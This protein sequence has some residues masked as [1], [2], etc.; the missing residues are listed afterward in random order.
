MAIPSLAAGQN[1]T[2]DVVVDRNSI[3]LGEAFHMQIKVEGTNRKLDPDLSA[4]ENCDIEF[5]GSRGQ[6]RHSWSRKNGRVEKVSEVSRV[7]SYSLTPYEAGEFNAGPVSIQTGGRMIVDQGVKVHVTGI[8][9][10]ELVYVDINASRES[11]L[12]V[13]SFT[14]ALRIGIEKLPP[15]YSSN[16]PLNPNDPPLLNVPFLELDPV[17]GLER[18][19][20]NAIL[21]SLLAKGRNQPGF[22]INGIELQG[23][24]STFG[25]FS[26]P[27]EK[28]Q[29]KFVLPRRTVTKN[30]KEYFEY[31][32]QLDYSAEEHGTYTFGPVEFKGSVISGV[33][34]NRDAIM[35]DVFAVGPA[36][37]VRVIPP[38]EEGRPPSYIGAIGSNLVASS[39]LDSQTCNVGDPLQL[40]L[41][42][43]GDA[44]LKNTY[45]P[46][47]SRV[48]GLSENFKVYSDT[49]KTENGRDSR[50][51]IYTIRPV[52]AGTVELPPLPVSYFDSQTRTYKTVRTSA[53]PV[54]VRQAT[55][56]VTNIVVSTA[57]DGL[58]DTD[59]I[60]IPAPLRPVPEVLSQGG[61]WGYTW[62]IYALTFPPLLVLIAR[63]GL[64]TREFFY[65]RRSS[66]L[67]ARA[68]HR[69]FQSLDAEFENAPDYSSRAGAIARNLC[70][71]V[72]RRLQLDQEALT[73]PDASSRLQAAGV[74]PELV[75]SFRELA[76]HCFDSA[77]SP[78][79]DQAG[80]DILYRRR[81]DAKQ[82]IEAIE[83]DIRHGRKRSRHAAAS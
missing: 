30:G 71:Y 17:A 79:T 2:L 66:G 7:Y 69:T 73:P 44:R 40:S 52:S 51:F 56:V 77:Y 81:E 18:P 43:S 53:M 24:L 39:S 32:L 11:T 57:R 54:K 60:Y 31:H 6:T 46:E 67:A 59:N 72:S 13:D 37:T 62:Q 55:E 28:K 16:E 58:V 45:P 23:G 47:I 8:E 14:I 61:R 48:P 64:K 22:N 19:D 41:A 33:T 80:S 3:Y 83:E 42:V 70:S 68:A 38:P 1:I 10:Q 49:V 35:K 5:L 78:G 4:I 15:P 76:Q 50:V 34:E 29:A 82:V 20:I 27:F 36:A 65:A 9:Q 21:N 75:D 63:C 74:R 25:M 26:D 12:I